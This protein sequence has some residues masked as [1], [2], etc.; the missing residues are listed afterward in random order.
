LLVRIASQLSESVQTSGF[1]LADPEDAIDIDQHHDCSQTAV[2]MLC[3]RNAQP[4][5][6]ITL[7][8]LWHLP[9]RRWITATLWRP[10]DL[11]LRWQACSIG[12]VAVRYR[13]WGY[14]HTIDADALATEIVEGIQSWL[15]QL[16]GGDAGPSRTD[17]PA[18]RT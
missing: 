2:Q 4:G 6:L 3:Y 14:D 15:D 7:L 9:E 17:R 13:S 10:N 8:E 1:A 16:E 11:A 5:R 12:E 18:D